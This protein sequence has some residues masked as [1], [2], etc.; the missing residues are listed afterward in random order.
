VVVMRRRE[1]LFGVQR[2]VPLNRALSG[3]GPLLWSL[4]P[5]DWMLLGVSRCFQKP[6]PE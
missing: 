5:S 4:T 6:N 3:T 2:M 1:K